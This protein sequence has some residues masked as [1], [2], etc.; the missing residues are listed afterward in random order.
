MQFESRILDP[1]SWIQDPGC[2][3]LDAGSW[4]R[5]KEN[6]CFL[7]GG[8]RRESYRRIDTTKMD[9]IAAR[10]YLARSRPPK[11][12]KFDQKSIKLYGS[13]DPRISGIEIPIY[14]IY[15]IALF[16]VL[17]WCHCNWTS[18]DHLGPPIWENLGP[19]G[20]PPRTT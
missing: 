16:G 15:P 13:S 10:I 8:A 5:T 6:R 19:P 3:I 14:P 12:S 11:P 2:R 4:I 1:G 17:C 9:R 18:W 7:S 20:G